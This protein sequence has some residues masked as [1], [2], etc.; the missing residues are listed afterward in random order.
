MENAGLMHCLRC[1]GTLERSGKEPYRHICSVC[2]QHFFLEMRLTPVEAPPLLL[3]EPA[4]AERSPG[5]D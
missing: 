5:T 3:Q 4:I 2:G 1:K